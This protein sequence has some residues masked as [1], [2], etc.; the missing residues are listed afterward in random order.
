MILT[1]ANSVDKMDLRMPSTKHDTDYIEYVS[2]DLSAQL[3]D[4][5]KLREAVRTA[6][7]AAR[8][9]STNRGDRLSVIRFPEAAARAQAPVKV[10]RW[11]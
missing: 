4:L 6:E 11:H 8:C 7:A 1:T 9:R 3:S 2:Q 10:R 5:R